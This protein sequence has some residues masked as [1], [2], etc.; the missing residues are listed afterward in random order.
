MLGLPELMVT[1]LP[2][3]LAAGMLNHVAGVTSGGTP[4]P[5]GTRTTLES[6]MR[7][8]VVEV[9]QPDAHMSIAIEI[10][11]PQIAARQLVWSDARGRMPWERGY[12]R[13]RRSQPVLGAR[14]A[15]GSCG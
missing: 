4:F 7:V 15:T 13:G 1:G 5:A 11:G 6:G 10:Y 3:H 14:S 2:P 12:R 8:E 9:T